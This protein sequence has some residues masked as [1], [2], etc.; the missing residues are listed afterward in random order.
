MTRLTHVRLLVVDYPGCFRFYRD[1]MGFEVQ[2]GDEGTGYADFA[3]S[4]GV[5]LAL[6]GRAEMAV[7]IGV[8]DPSERGG[9]QAVLV[10]QAD[11]LDA[12]VA[13]LEDLGAGFVA[14]PTDRP[15][16]GIRTA[17]LRDPDGNLIELYENLPS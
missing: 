8:S 1:V 16:W 2:F 6:F 11:A 13:L 10:I 3:A 9:D 15:D 5:T 12:D 14:P 7:A 17:H 4:P